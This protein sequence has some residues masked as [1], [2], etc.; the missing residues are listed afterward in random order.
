V[1]LPELEQARV[2]NE[3]EGIAL[4]TQRYRDAI[5][6][7]ELPEELTA[8]SRAEELTFMREWD[9]LDVV[10]RSECWKATGKAPLQSKW[11]GVN[12]GD[13]ARPVVRSVFV[14]K[15]FADKRSDEFFAATPR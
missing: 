5:T 13:F 15:E 2:Q 8:A 10:P 6:H 3:E 9:V 11:V 12:K 1:V 7:E 4:Y 14:A